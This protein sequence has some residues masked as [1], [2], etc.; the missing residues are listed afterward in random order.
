M[1]FT[2]GAGIFALI[3]VGVFTWWVLKQEAGTS[4]MQEIA[5]FIQQG[6]NW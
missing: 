2:P 4:R 5:F 1:L 3:F 6:A